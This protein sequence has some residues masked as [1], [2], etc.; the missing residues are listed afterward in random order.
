MVT[1]GVVAARTLGALVAGLR[2]EAGEVRGMI[3]GMESRER[4]ERTGEEEARVPPRNQA[5]ELLE[6]SSSPS[7]LVLLMTF[8]LGLRSPEIWLRG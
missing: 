7:V 4:E 5:V 3:P 8:D 6:C 2:A 1:W